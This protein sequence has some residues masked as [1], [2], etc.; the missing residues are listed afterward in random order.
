MAKAEDSNELTVPALL[1]G[2]HKLSAYGLG[3]IR[4]ALPNHLAPERI[5]RVALTTW[6]NSEGLQK[7]DP[8]SFMNAVVQAAQLGLEPN[9]AI[10]Q[11][12]LIPYGRECQL[13]IGYK[14]L[15]HLA[16]RSPDVLMVEGH[17]VRK[18]DA[19]GFEYGS[20]GFVKHVPEIE[21]EPEALDGKEESDR[22]NIRCFWAGV[23]LRGGAYKFHVMS[24]RDV[25][26]IERRYVKAKGG[27]WKTNYAEMGIKTVLRR[28]LKQIPL[29]V[30][31]AE[32]VAVDE[33]N[34]KG[35]TAPVYMGAAEV[36]QP[37]DLTTLIS[38]EQIDELKKLAA[39]GDAAEALDGF[40]GAGG[41]KSLADIPAS[42]FELAK[43]VC[44]AKS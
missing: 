24:A 6:K 14:G 30:E 11:A 26:D 19:F 40:L 20:H 1:E 7:C 8:L 28:L 16:H 5:A 38:P 21:D 34:E 35:E 42:Q 39:D 13:V 41:Y 4:K 3:Q 25:F 2:K 12:Y 43:A 44:N 29:T 22:K 33:A 37:S 10:G 9:N 31:M 23:Q 27:P 36:I 17:A 18:G 32:A 15:I